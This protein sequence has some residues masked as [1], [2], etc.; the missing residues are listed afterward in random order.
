MKKPNTFD[1]IP[2]SNSG[3]FSFQREKKNIIE[4]LKR[5]QDAQEQQLKQNLKLEQDVEM[6]KLR[7]VR[8]SAK[9]IEERFEK[10]KNEQHHYYESAVQCFHLSG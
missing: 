8:E 1:W 7:K 9:E 10:R 4:L 2:R 3:F 5:R 6:E